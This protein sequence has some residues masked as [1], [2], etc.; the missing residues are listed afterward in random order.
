MIRAQ[1][2]LNHF[3][4]SKGKK[5]SSKLEHGESHSRS[6]FW[7]KPINPYNFCGNFCHL[8]NNYLDVAHNM[9]KRAWDHCGNHSHQ[10][11]QTNIMKQASYP[12]FDID[13]T[14]LHLCECDINV[15]ELQYEFLLDL[16]VD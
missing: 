1:N 2:Q 14:S 16:G 13:K 10:N 12:S 7:H 8:M 15:L 5:N 6:G 11:L 3:Q 4:A 9:M